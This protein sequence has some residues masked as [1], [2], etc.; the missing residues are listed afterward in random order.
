MPNIEY[1]LI[2]VEQH[3]QNTSSVISHMYINHYITH[4]QQCAYDTIL[5]EFKVKYVNQDQSQTPCC[6]VSLNHSSIHVT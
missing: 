1:G 4:I 6:S 2:F 5:Y 3:N